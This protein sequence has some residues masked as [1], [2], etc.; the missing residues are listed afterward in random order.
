MVDWDECNER[1]FKGSMNDDARECFSGQYLE[2][3]EIMSIETH[4]FFRYLG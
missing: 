2:L 4:H 1:Y 3:M